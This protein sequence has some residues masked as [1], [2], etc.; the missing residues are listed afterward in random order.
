MEEQFK[1]GDLVQL[2]SGSP[3]MTINKLADSAQNN[4]VECVWFDN[5]NAGPYYATFL[6]STLVAEPL[7][8]ID[9]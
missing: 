5:T 7:N 1:L 8:P 2:K 4:G 6:K 9:E 3:V